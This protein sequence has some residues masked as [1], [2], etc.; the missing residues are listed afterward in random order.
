MCGPLARKKKIRRE[1]DTLENG[2]EKGRLRVY[3]NNN[4]NNNNNNI[5]NKGNISLRRNSENV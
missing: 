3:N 2:C 4:N 5:N 1:G